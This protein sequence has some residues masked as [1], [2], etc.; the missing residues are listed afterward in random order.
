MAKNGDTCP[1]HPGQPVVASC[2]RFDR[3]YCEIDFQ[4]HAH[5]V[6]CLSAGTHCSERS[7][8][9]VW[10]RMKEEKRLRRRQKRGS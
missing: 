7:R 1:R 9:M 10:A 5:P 3:R 6:E 4:D 8:C 2:L